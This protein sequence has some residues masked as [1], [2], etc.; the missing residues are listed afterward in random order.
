MTKLLDETLVQ[1]HDLYHLRYG[2]GAVVVAIQRGDGDTPDKKR[3]KNHQYVA[4]L[5]NERQTGAGASAPDFE[6]IL[7]IQEEAGFV[8]MVVQ[9]EHRNRVD[10]K[11]NSISATIERAVPL[12]QVT[13][14]IVRTAERPDRD[15]G[16]TRDRRFS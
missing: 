9:F 13:L 4:R 14:E 7:S 5:Y 12:D 15:R 8:R 2:R 16:R 3:A 1:T 11:Y 10:P 6:P